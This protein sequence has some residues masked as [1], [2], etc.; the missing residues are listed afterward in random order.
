MLTRK[1]LAMLD[2]ARDTLVV[3]RDLVLHAAFASKVEDRTP[4]AHE[5]DVTIAQSRQPETLV[6]ACVFR[7]AD[8]SAGG[9]KQRYHGRK[10]FLSRQIWK[11]QIASELAAQLRQRIAEGNHTVEL[12]VVAHLPPLRMVAI[13]LAA[14][15]VLAGGLQVAAWAE[16]DPDVFVGRR[17]GETRDTFQFAGGRQSPILWS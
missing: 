9:V 1:I 17:P 12:R 13:L 16:A 2:D 6:V 3:D 14:A 4:V 5:G 7:V 15:R 11:R 8:A 10:Y